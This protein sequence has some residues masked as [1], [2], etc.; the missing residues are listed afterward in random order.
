M[1]VVQRYPADSLGSHRTYAV[2]MGNIRI[3]IFFAAISVCQ[4]GFGIY[5]TVL[6]AKNKRKVKLL[7]LR[8]IISTVPITLLRSYPRS[9]ATPTD[10]L[11]RIQLVYICPTQAPRDCDC[12]NR[13]PFWCVAQPRNLQTDLTWRATQT[14]QT[15]SCFR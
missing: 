2:T 9:P 7:D 14:N 3:T 10:T 5:L 13:P 1:F 4:L 12:S 6:A 11:R 8:S 15:F